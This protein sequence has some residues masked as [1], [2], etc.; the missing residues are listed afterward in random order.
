LLV[1]ADRRAQISGTETSFPVLRSVP[2]S[3]VPPAFAQS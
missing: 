3:Y 2:C 1:S